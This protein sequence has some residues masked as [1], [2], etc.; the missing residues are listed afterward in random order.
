MPFESRLFIK[1]AL[2]CFV[3]A[4]LLGGLRWAAFLGFDPGWLAGGGPAHVHLFVFGWITEMI[5][6]VALWLFPVV[7]RDDPRGSTKLQYLAWVGIT[8]GLAARVVA[9]PLSTPVGGTSVWDWTL[10]GSAIAQ[11]IGGLAFT[12]DI[13]PRIQ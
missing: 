12:I 4:L 5:I 8:G 10:L 13:W 11:C 9:E 7:D 1:T 6:G 3:A 2:V